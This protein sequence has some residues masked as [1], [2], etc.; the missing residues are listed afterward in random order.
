VKIDY[1]TQN[2]RTHHA[3]EKLQDDSKVIKDGVSCTNSAAPSKLEATSIAADASDEARSP[4]P[5]STVASTAPS[6][7]ESTSDALSANEAENT[8]FPSAYRKPQQQLLNSTIKTTSGTVSTT[9]YLR[10]TAK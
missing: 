1:L 3:N 10:A 4:I 5:P 6:I 2:Y 7:R 9:Y 8:I